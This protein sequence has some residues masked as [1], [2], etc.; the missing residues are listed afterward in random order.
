MN[1]K[2]FIEATQDKV[3]PLEVD[4]NWF[5]QIIQG[6]TSRAVETITMSIENAEIEV[7]LSKIHI[8][9]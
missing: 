1:Y 7:E 5:L 8:V 6:K 9:H 4:E 2:I 3:L